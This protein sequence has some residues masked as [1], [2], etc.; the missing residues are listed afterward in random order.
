MSNLLVKFVVMLK[1]IYTLAVSYITT[2]KGSR[3]KRVYLIFY[4]YQNTHELI[5]TLYILQEEE[6][7]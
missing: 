5:F 7:A 6:T 4:P 3:K 1:W 2:Q